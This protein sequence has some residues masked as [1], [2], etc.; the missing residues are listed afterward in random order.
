M[1]I[2]PNISLHSTANPSKWLSE[3]CVSLC[4]CVCVRVMHNISDAGITCIY[5]SHLCMQ[6]LPEANVEGGVQGWVSG[7]H[8][9]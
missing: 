5:I 1:D 6:Q 9:Q 8:V 2:L 4:V 7:E 3:S